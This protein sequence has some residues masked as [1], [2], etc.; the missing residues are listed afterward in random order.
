MSNLPAQIEGAS[1][2]SASRPPRGGG[3]I[4]WMAR[5][6]VMPNLL[7]LALII[8]GLLFS[9]RI[10]QEVFPTYE[11]D[12]VTISM[13][14]PGAT[15]GEV[16]DAL[17][18]SIE[19]ALST[20]IGISKVSAVVY[21]GHTRITAQLE[22][23][24]EREVVYS[25][26]QQAVN[27]I[28]T[29]PDDAE[30]P[31]F[32]MTHNLRDV[33]E[34]QVHG[35]VAPRA[36]RMAAEQV[37][38]A[39][40]TAP[41][42]SQIKIERVPDMEIHAEIPRATLRA[43][44]LTLGE[45]GNT[46]RLGAQD[47]SGGRVETE[48]GD[49]QL[50]IAERRDSLA[51]FADLPV[52]VNETGSV[53]RLG[54][55]ARLSHGF[56][57]SQHSKTF[58]GKPSLLVDVRLGPNETP[59]AIADAV[60]R[61]LPD[62]RDGLPAA[63]DLAITVDTSETYRGRLQ[64]LLKN[65]FIGLCLVLLVLSLFLEFRLAFWVA[66]GI[67]T[68]F[69]GT[70]LFLPSLGVSIN[71]VSMFAYILA[72]GLVVDDAIVAGENI[73][74]YRER[75]MD[76]VEAAVA[77]A[78]DISVP[79]SF[80]IITNVIAFLPLAMVPG[81]FG[82]F[83]VVIPLVVGTAFLISWIEALFVLPGHL[84]AVR[85]RET[86]RQG[87]LARI[88]SGFSGGLAWVT[89]RLYGPLLRCAMSWRYATVA[90]MILILA[91][92]AAWPMSGRMGF[93]LF[94]PIPRDDARA[95]VTLPIDAPDSAKEVVRAR[96]VTAAKEVIAENGGDQLS[97][98]ILA[99]IDGQTIK[100]R[101]YL[102]PPEIR[103]ISTAEFVRQ[104]R[105]TLGPVPDAKSA[106]FVSSF[107]GPGGDANLQVTLS[108]SDE[109][110]LR[111]AAMALVARLNE[112][113]AVRDAQDGFAEGKAERAFRITEAGR[114]MG[115]TAGA[116]ANQ[117]R[118]AFF[119]VEALRQQEGRNEITL[120]L[121]LPASERRSEYDIETLILRAPDGSEAPLYEIAEVVH[122]RADA[123]INREHGRRQI[124]VSASVDPPERTRGIQ[125][126]LDT[127]ILPAL[128]ADFPG[129]VTGYGGRQETLRETMES[130]RVSVVIALVIMYTVL[131]IPFRSWIQPAI[132][133]T[134]IPFGFAGAVM[135]HILMGMSLS[136]ISIFGVIALGGVVINTAL[137]MIDY[138]NKVRLEGV[139]AFEAMERAGL[140][141]FRPIVLTTLTTFGGLAPMI[142]ETS[143]Q[144]RFLIPM[145]VSLGYGI[146]FATL[147]VLLLIP[148][149]YLI[150]EDLR[151]LA[152]PRSRP[153]EARTS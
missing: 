132:V 25:D 109:P 14:L 60:R 74:E 148:A 45:V 114:A 121:R 95:S 141:R 42:I 59:I 40:L 115:L 26:V 111:A 131:A 103:P 29:F 54:E 19:D 44:G 20:V 32:S 118:D 2:R 72:L 22:D 71:M 63:I 51:D 137:V 49:L 99:E 100:L 93:S 66:V 58:D 4:G 104:W 94:P 55:I 134:A 124:T 145:A 38:S 112:F 127:T 8:G 36:L 152:N 136:I 107:G 12:S 3:A 106:S 92:T 78:R 130:F 151:W 120:R 50:R 150:V 81:W 126:A 69:L 90:L 57:D 23:G 41:E 142:F 21:E 119:G 67:P 1:P 85:K 117:V 153:V 143:L 34:L 135:G 48:A 47:R 144:A 102:Q 110:T 7:M 91:L 97:R 98:G 31:R 140:R 84:A 86:R 87:R 64:L 16:E 17:V 122:D 13:A 128:R 149:L 133:M 146:V 61:M 5:H 43:H 147:V 30:A 88:R 62:L 129:L 105:D 33:I 96:M 125:T 73:F 52:V 6:P 108:H 79:L 76:P 77:G 139:S 89:R 53:L 10:R 9:T 39:L 83:W 116:V 68:A 28:S 56:A 35:D 101:V 46:L 75:G 18:L 15:P 82:K 11:L 138:A 37:R 123:E 70:L 113:A 65:G 24:A 80:S 27:A